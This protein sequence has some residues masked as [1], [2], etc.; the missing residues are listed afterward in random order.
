MSNEGALEE[1]AGFR[2]ILDFVEVKGEAIFGAHNVMHLLKVGLRGKGSS[3]S[4]QCDIISIKYGI[5]LSGIRRYLDGDS[6]G[7]RHVKGFSGGDD[8]SCYGLCLSQERF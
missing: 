2:I 4:K 1:S 8:G 6:E 7:G 5:A 3:N